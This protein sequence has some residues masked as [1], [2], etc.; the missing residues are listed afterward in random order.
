MMRVLFFLLLATSVCAGELS[1]VN[2]SGGPVRLVSTNASF[3]V[4]S[5][6]TDLVLSFAGDLE[7]WVF[8]NQV[9]SVALSGV[10]ES[11]FA[12]VVVQVSESDVTWW[13]QRTG[14]QWALYGLT[15]GFFLGGTSWVWRL[16]RQIGRSSPEM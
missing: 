11:A 16:V 14:V 2:A 13:E 4:P 9:G 8:T 1:V 15:F 6:R 10:D 3:T 12:S 5:G 7:V